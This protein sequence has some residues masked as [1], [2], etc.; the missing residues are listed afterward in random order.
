MPGYQYREDKNGHLQTGDSQK[1]VEQFDVINHKP[2]D[3]VQTHIWEKNTDIDDE[4]DG[5]DAELSIENI[6]LS[7]TFD[8]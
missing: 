3:D 6:L 2:S 5:L 7:H 4:A 1:K 8:R